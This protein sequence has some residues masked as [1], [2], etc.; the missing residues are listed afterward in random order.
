MKRK[1][2]LISVGA[3]LVIVV[4]WFASSPYIA[5][6]GLHNALV[7]DDTD[8]INRTVDFAAIREHLIN[9]FDIAAA[10]PAPVQNNPFSAMEAAFL[11]LLG[12]QVIDVLASPIGIAAL[13]SEGDSPEGP[14]GRYTIEW[15][16]IGEF[17]ASFGDESGPKL[18]FTRQGF[19]W[20][21]TR[22]ELPPEAFE[23]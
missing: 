7:S 9:D 19:R 11:E 6:R 23:A 17:W 1:P 4:I 21:L 18:V 12:D 13:M 16:G 14:L 5:V 2:L 8:K 22:L 20:Q 15:K 3:I 10:L